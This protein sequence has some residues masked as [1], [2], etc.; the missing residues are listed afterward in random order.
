LIGTKNLFIKIKNESKS[1]P[2][3]SKS[4]PAADGPRTIVMHSGHPPTPAVTA[5][6]TDAEAVHPCPCRSVTEVVARLYASEENQIGKQE[7]NQLPMIKIHRLP[8]R[9]REIHQWVAVAFEE[10]HRLQATHT[11]PRR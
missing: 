1:K 3:R 7:S 4:E 5:V 10:P 9:H 6:V 2:V 8:H 11:R